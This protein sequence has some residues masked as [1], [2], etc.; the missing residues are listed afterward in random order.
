VAKFNLRSAY[1]YLVCLV[2]LVIF[3]SG[4]IFSITNLT[5]LFL[6]EGYYQTAEE[7]AMRFERLD[8]KTGQTQTE[9]TPAEIQNRYAEYLRAEKNRQYNRNLRELINSLA[10]LIVGGCF[11]VY[12]W[13][14]IG[15]DRE[16]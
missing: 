4:I 9:L 7:F 2:T 8:P 1:L 11:W 3:I 12:H 16:S 14:Q 13:R 15:A 5:D 10:A 6:D